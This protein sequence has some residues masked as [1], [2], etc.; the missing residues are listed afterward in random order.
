M[1]FSLGHWSRAYEAAKHSLPATEIKRLFNDEGQTLV[2]AGRFREA[3]Q[4]FVAAQLID[5]A[6]EMYR[7]SKNYDQLIRV[8]SNHLPDQLSRYH[9]DIARQLQADG[10]RKSAE[11][12]FI[13]VRNIKTRPFNI[14]SSLPKIG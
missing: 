2:K 4:L 8:I 6:V 3:E 10:N 11:K 9:L 1:G 7:S 13:A 12:H 5:S 14:V